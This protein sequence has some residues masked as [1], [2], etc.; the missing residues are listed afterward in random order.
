[1]FVSLVVLATKLLD[2]PAV[3]KTYTTTDALNAMQTQI[4]AQIVFKIFQ[5]TTM[6][7]VVVI[8]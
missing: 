4:S 2:L 8:L 1:M 7:T 5:S 3:E 6:D